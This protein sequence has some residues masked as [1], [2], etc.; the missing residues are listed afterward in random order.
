M[1][2]MRSKRGST[3]DVCAHAY[4][5]RAETMR[6]KHLAARALAAFALTGIWRCAAAAPELPQMSIVPGGV[7]SV[8]LDAPETPAPIV[9]FDGNRTL[10]LKDAQGWLAIVGLPLSAAPGTASV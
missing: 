4:W 7:L 10:V 3:A 5:E 2:A 8:R 1:S 6:H 9:T